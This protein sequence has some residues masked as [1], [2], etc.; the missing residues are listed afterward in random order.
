[1]QEVESKFASFCCALACNGQLNV[2]S[3]VHNIVVN[4]PK[5]YLRQQLLSHSLAMRER[6]LT[7]YLRTHFIINYNLYP[8]YGLSNGDAHYMQ[9]YGGWH[10]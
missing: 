9:D 7:R 6:G 1:M 4:G 3:Y 5:V 2:R 8:Y 10:H